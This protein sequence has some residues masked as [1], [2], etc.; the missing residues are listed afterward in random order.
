[1][2][3]IIVIMSIMILSDDWNTKAD[4]NMIAHVLELQVRTRTLAA[5]R[6]KRIVPLEAAQEHQALI[7]FNL[8]VRVE[9]KA[10]WMEKRLK[11]R[12]HTVEIQRA[13]CA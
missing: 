1:M 2:M 12:G 6:T 5:R 10:L 7:T 3:M 11:K 9:H 4:D 13:D 8:H